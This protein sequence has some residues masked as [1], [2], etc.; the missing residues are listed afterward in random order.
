MSSSL[1]GLGEA[2]VGREL[3]E[4]VERQELQAVAAIELLGPD[5]GGDGRRTSA[6][7]RSSR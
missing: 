5:H 2:G 6:L 3:V 7:R 4:R 1:V